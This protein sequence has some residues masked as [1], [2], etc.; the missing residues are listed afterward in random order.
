MG[1]KGKP[2]VR[3]EKKEEEKKILEEE[4]KRMQELRKQAAAQLKKEI[5][6]EREVVR[7]CETTV[8]GKLKLRH[9]L[10]R[11]KGI[12]HSLAPVIPVVAGLDPE[13][14]IGN[15]TDQ[16]IELIENI[17]RNPLD[18]GIP[19]FLLN[20]RRDPFDGKSKHLI[21]SDLEVQIRQDIEFLK[22]IRAYR[23]IR[24]E[25]GL[26]VRGQ[27]TRSSFRKGKTVGVQRKKK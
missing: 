24:H 14:R 23:G 12:G 22:K 13:M 6:V 15:L 4:K 8:D 26:P 27:R 3:D 16:Q 9:G 10:L 7:I 2:R 1:G 11:V 17:I 25:L 18:Y 5:K 21:A 20:R 19:E